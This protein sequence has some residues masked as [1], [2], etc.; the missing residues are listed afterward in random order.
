MRWPL[1]ALLTLFA[2]RHAWPS[3]SMVTA[4]PMIDFGK[5]KG[6]TIEDVL[7]SDPDYAGWL[8]DTFMYGEPSPSMQPAGQWL[9]ENNPD[10][11]GSRPVGFGKYKEKTRESVVA[12]DPEYAEWV[13]KASQEGSKNSNFRH[14]A[15]L[16]GYQQLSH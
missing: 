15:E 4:P 14:F 2:W 12:D 16:L 13:I 5:H 10:L 8:L 7:D 11:L 9:L 1:V 6:E 3:F